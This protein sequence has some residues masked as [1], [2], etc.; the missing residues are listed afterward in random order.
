MIMSQ[1]GSVNFGLLC[2]AVS[3]NTNAT[4]QA[5]P[6][7]FRTMLSNTSHV[8]PA[9]TSNSNDIT[10]IIHKLFPLPEK[11]ESAELSSRLL[12]IH[13]QYYLFVSR[14]CSCG[15]SL[16]TVAT[17]QSRYHK[18]VI[19]TSNRI[20]TWTLQYCNSILS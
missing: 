20:P 5:S 8:L 16:I 3:Y 4:V 1:V 17:N 7:Q 2:S 6:L 11:S 19:H 13:L 12:H 18:Q 15:I 14:I 10:A 9:F